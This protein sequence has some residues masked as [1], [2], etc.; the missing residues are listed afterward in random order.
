[1]RLT[2]RPTLAW[3]RPWNYGNAPSQAAPTRHLRTIQTVA[4]G[5]ILILSILSSASAIAQQAAQTGFDPRQTEKYFEDLQ[6]RERAHPARPG[7]RMPVLPRPVFTGDAK[8]LFVLQGVT[9]TGALA[10]P[11]DRLSTSYQP[12]LGKKV[13]Q[14]DLAA[15]AGSIS[16]RYRAAGF[17]LSRAIVPPQDIQDGRIH[18][19]LIEGSIAEVVLRG[20]GAEQFGIRP[21]LDAV[22]AEHPSQLMTLERQLLLINGRPG[23][24]IVDTALEEIDGPTGRFRLIV[25]LKTWHIWDPRR[26]A[27]GRLMRRARLIPISFPA[28]RWR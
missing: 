6:S 12:Y 8:P 24:R 25:Y 23:V 27:H 5:L 15:I 21:L 22:L 28:I 4:A 11:P 9:I 19:Q 17:H 10:V 20:D 16:D 26:S 3:I 18:I 2:H 14:A 13:S 1:M 7:L